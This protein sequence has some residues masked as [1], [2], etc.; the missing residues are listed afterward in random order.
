M[1]IRTHANPLS[2]RKRFDKIHPKEIFK[3][4]DNKLDLE[5]GFGQSSFILQ[6]AQDN[7]DRS[8]V[9]IEV[10]K[11]AVEIMQKKVDVQKLENIFLVHGN[12]M[13]CLQDMFGDHSIDKIFIFHPDPWIKSRHHKRR[14]INFEFLQIL[15][16]KLKNGANVYVS[17]DVDFLWEDICKNF[18]ASNS[19]IKVK[20]DDFWQN[21]YSGRW[22]EIVKAKNRQTFFAT[23][24]LN[25]Y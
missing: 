2:N 8:I 1:R 21:Y 14:L 9:G 18:E 24:C 5:I 4:F 13:V 19:F 3:D 25:K 15:Q 17:T 23:F 12:G 10:R 20:D 16:G 6:Y 7:L 22:D 11:K